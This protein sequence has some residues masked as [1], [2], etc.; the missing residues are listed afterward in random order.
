MVMRL[1]NT[2]TGKFEE[3]LEESKPTYA[4][5]SHRWSNDECSLQEFVEGQ[6]THSAGY[7][8]IQSFCKFVR[9]QRHSYEWVWVDTCCI[10]KKS[11]A[12]VTEAINSMY[13]WYR[14]AKA[15]F[16]Y[17]KDLPPK[18]QASADERRVAF[19]SSDWFRRGW[20]LQELLAPARVDFCDREWNIYGSRARLAGSI[21]AI[22]GID[23]AFL[24]GRQRPQEASV[25]MR[26]SWA[27]NRST[28]K[29]EDMAY[30]LLGIFDVNM[31][32]LYG[33]KSKA[34]TRLQHEIIKS[35]DDESIFAWESNSN[36]AGGMLATSPK[37]FKK[38]GRIVNIRLRPEERMPYFI[39]NKGLQI[40]SA[41]DTRAR[42]DFDQSTA[43]PMGYRDHVLELGC[44]SGSRKVV[45]A[46]DSDA[47]EL[48]EDGALTVELKRF[49]P[50]WKRINCS[51]LGHAN[52]ASRRR[53]R[54]GSYVGRGVQRL[55]LVEL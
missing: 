6:K 54:N 17:L 28:T 43:Q 35:S 37:S 5:L 50:T 48:W 11:S 38:A 18:R 53:R 14:K 32:P 55:Y 10:D 22:T 25:A 9:G 39:T 23:V 49:G 12:E 36:A 40:R 4:I 41:S 44:F 19:G 7:E 31:P 27:S 21:A 52:N 51:R 15:C 16:V 33:E 3:F 26:M 1:L 46:E 20:T 8:K 34:F 42:D 45:T 47:E 29:S 30:C 13:E 24:D 2:N